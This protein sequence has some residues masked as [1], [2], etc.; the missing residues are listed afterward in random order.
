M[1]STPSDVLARQVRHWRNERRLSTQDLSNRL[2]E[3]GTTKLNR[4]VISKIESGERGVTID[5][6]LQLAHALAV[7][8][9]LL[10]MDLDSGASVSIAPKVTLHPWIVWG[11]I[12]GEHASP[13]PS[14]HGDALISRVEE[15]SR[16]AR[17]VQLYRLEEK[18]SDA[19]HNALSGIRTAEYT[20]EEQALKA[21][22]AAHIDALRELGRTFDSMIENEM[23][24]PGKPKKWVEAIREFKLSKYPDKLQI[25]TPQED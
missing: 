8:P 16:A 17:A 4:R 14:E 9:P 5:E 22:R 25:W 12:A 10:L 13:V 2:T 6:W 23:T 19:V 20:G 1:T 7:P 21:A 24:P 11:W 3:L 15:F 18:A